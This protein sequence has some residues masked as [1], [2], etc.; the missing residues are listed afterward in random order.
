[1]LITTKIV[2][3]NRLGYKCSLTTKR[4]PLNRLYIGLRIV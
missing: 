1:M 2:L 4:V 3:L